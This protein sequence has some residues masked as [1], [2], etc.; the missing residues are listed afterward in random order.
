MGVEK[1]EKL[2]VIAW[3]GDLDRAWPTLILATTAAASGWEVGVFFTFWGLFLLVRNDVRI[4]GTQWM[5]KMLSLMNRP[6][7]RHAKL[8]KLNFAGMGPW[9]M[10]KLASEYKVPSPE[11]LISLARDMGVKLMPCQMTM[12]LLGLKRQDLIEGVGEP[13][14]AAAAIQEMKEAAVTLF[15]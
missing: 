4:T 9:M 10:R 6:G 8:T 7:T 2:V 5:Q 13:L 3:G 12:D 11:E 1:K 14:G 15:I